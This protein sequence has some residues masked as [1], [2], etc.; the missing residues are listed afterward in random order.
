MPHAETLMRVGDNGTRMAVVLVD[1]LHPALATMQEDSDLTTKLPSL[2]TTIDQA[3]P[4]LVEAEALFSQLLDDYDTLKESPELMALVPWSVQQQLDKFD[5]LLPFAHDMLKLAPYTPALAGYPEPVT[6]LVVAQN[7]D[8]IR[9]T[10]G[11]ISAV[12]PLSINQGQIGSFDFSDTYAIDD[13]TKPYD[14][15]PQPLYDYMGAELFILR[16]SN[17]WPHF[18]TSAEKMRALY[19]YT[20]DTPAVDGVITIDLTMLELLVTA[21][22]PV[23]VPELNM[24]LTQDNVHE[25]IYQAWEDGT[26]PQEESVLAWLSTRKSFM[27]PVS[28]ALRTKLETDFSNIDWLKLAQAIEQASKQKNLQIYTTNQSVYTALSTINWAGNMTAPVA[29]DTLGIIETNMGF[30]KVNPKIERQAHYTIHLSS[31]AGE[32]NTAE[33]DIQYTH[34]GAPS[35]ALCSATLPSYSD[36]ITYAEAADACYR[37]YLRILAPAA[38]QLTTA[39]V[40]PYPASYFFN[41]ADK[42]GVAK[43]EIDTITKH[44]VFSNFVIVPHEQTI[45]TQFK[46]QLP[47]SIITTNTDGSRQYHLTVHKQAGAK[48]FP[49]QVTINLPANMSF[50]S[51]NIPPTS[52]TSTTITFD[53]VVENDQEIEVL[54][55]P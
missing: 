38:S 40:H 13:F 3:Q 31:G 4:E 17:F 34:T 22:E 23:F 39:S 36:G 29:S 35:E 26:I 47:P 33:L 45:L 12:A 1:G 27:G 18:P 16:D 6:Y 5:P 2:M 10:G 44:T 8:E 53:L 41:D 15:P 42:L 32:T 25:V 50:L 7:S 24:T 11:F 21:L 20:T 37:N 54:F 51:S 19:S 30:T 9:P 49:L 55:N 52:Q 46:Y 43:T 48:S 14:F 28:L